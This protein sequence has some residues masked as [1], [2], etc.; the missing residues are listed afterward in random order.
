MWGTEL[1]VIVQI[2]SARNNQLPYTQLQSALINGCYVI[3]VAV[4]TTN[5]KCAG[6]LWWNKY[7]GALGGDRL[8]NKQS[9][10]VWCHYVH[11]DVHMVGGNIL[12][13]TFYLERIFKWVNRCMLMQMQ[14]E[15]IY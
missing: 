9:A 8:V 13:N 7:E 14:G 10:A 6:S 2:D 1:L 5:W 11:I 4:A 3:L 15:H 12:S